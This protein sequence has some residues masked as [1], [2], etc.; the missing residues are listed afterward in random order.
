MKKILSLLVVFF[1]LTCSCH[2][3]VTDTESPVKIYTSATVTEYPIP[4]DYIEDED[5]EVTLVSIDTGAKI[6]QVLNVDYTI[7][8]DTV[9][10]ATAPGSSYE[11]IIRRVTPYTQEASW[12][13]G[14]APPLSAHESALDKL[15]FLTQDLNERLNRSLH[16]SV[17]STADPELPDL[18]VHPGELLRINL[19]GDAIDTLTVAASGVY[20]DFTAYCDPMDLTNM[21]Q[22]TYQSLGYLQRSKFTYTGTSTITI[23]P[24]VYD[25]VG[26]VYWQ[27]VF[28][29]SD[30]TFTNTFTDAGWYYLYIDDSS[31]P[32]APAMISDAN[33]ISSATAP[34]WSAIR[35]GWYNGEDR[36]IF[37]YFVFSG[38][39]WPFYHDGG[40]YVQYEAEGT[41]S[42]SYTD[43]SAAET[44][45]VQLPAFSTRG[46]FSLFCTLN[47]PYLVYV[48]TKASAYLTLGYGASGTNVR[49]P[50]FEHYTS[51][52]QGLALALSDY[53][54]TNSVSLQTNGWYFPTG[55]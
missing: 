50:L 30:L 21:R 1:I 49:F 24:G 10:Y 34:S 8:D 17:S 14:S 44:V 51:S 36:C 26:G 16:L 39:I 7:V 31:L 32:G 5:I 2:A 15:T 27:T 52:T 42:R 47:G 43:L 3:T 11:V 54:G 18:S 41:P 12:V 37:A 9:T 46:K 35:H 25:L 4:F 19:A 40:D 23:G 6:A 45:T 29:S 33:I 53:T 48:S 13:A 20:P 38:N 55:M 28:W 22:H